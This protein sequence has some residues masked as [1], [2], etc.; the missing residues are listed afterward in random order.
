MSAERPE[1]TACRRRLEGCSPGASRPPRGADPPRAE[2]AWPPL[3]FAGAVALLFVAASWFGLWLFA[4]PLARLVALVLFALALLAALARSSGCA[5]RDARARWPG[6][7]ATPESRIA[8]RRRSST[9]SPTTRTR[10]PARS[11]RCTRRGSPARSRRLASRRP[12]RAWPSAT[13][14]R[15]ASPRRCSPSRRR[16]RPARSSIAGFAAAFDWRGGDANAAAAGSRIDAWIDPPPY[17]GRRRWSSISK[18][19]TRDADGFRGFDAR[20]ARRPRG[21]RDAGRGA[22]Q[23]GRAEGGRDLRPR[24]RSGAAPSTATARRRSCAA[25]RR[26]PRSRSRSRRPESRP[27]S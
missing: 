7:T 5:G 11:G 19:R 13:P 24:R 10:S 23:P 27:S 14:T 6:S 3:A 1:T 15:C 9:R 25:A 18:P 16:S 26:P 4:P 8:R 20:R 2:G 12:P 21:G 22:D 17:T